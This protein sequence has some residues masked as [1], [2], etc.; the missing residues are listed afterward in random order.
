MRIV[1]EP[2]SGFQAQVSGRLA[3]DRVNPPSDTSIFADELDSPWH[4]V[5][6]LPNGGIC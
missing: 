2:I 5:W 6:S 3:Y 1:V 4:S